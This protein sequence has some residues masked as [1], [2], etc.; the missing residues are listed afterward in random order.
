[1]TSD[2]YPIVFERNV[3][4]PALVGTKQ[5]PAYQK[6]LSQCMYYCTKPKG[7]AQKSRADCLPECK[8]KCATS[9]DQKML[10]VPKGKGE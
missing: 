9:P 5:D 2:H 4:D 3:Q 8:E 10:G 6:C 1:M 7:D